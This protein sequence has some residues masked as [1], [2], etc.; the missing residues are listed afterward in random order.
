M[1][2]RY[3]VLMIAVFRPLF[4]ILLDGVLVGLKRPLSAFNRISYII[5][6]VFNS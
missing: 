3:V 2:N 6:V 1:G 5:N 4:I